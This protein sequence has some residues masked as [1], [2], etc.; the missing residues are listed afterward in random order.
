MTDRYKLVHFYSPTST[1]GSCST[2]EGP[3]GAQERLRRPGQCGGRGELE[4]GDGPPAQELKVPARPTQGGVRPARCSPSKASRRRE[5]RPLPA[6]RIDSVMERPKI[7]RESLEEAQMA[8]VLMPGSPPPAPVAARDRC[9]RSRRARRER[10]GRSEIAPTSSWSCRTTRATA[11][12]PATA[13]RSS[14]RR[15]STPSTGESVRFTDFHVSP[16]CAPTRMRADDRPARVQDRRHAHDPRARAAEPE[17]DDARPGAEVGR[18]HDGHLRQVAPRR[19]GRRISPTGA[20]STRC[21]S[22]AAAASARRTRAVAAMRRATPTSTRPSCT[23]ARSRRPKGYC[24]D[25]FFGQAMKWMDEQSQGRRTVLRL[26]HPQRRRTRRCNA[27]RS[28]PS[29]YAG[30]VPDE[31]REV[32]RHDREHR[33]QRR[34]AAGEAQASGASRTTR[35]SSS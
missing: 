22:T 16:T 33:R 8:R 19:R 13:I 29:G 5:R 11:I 34:P 21:S 23:T 2:S 10:R 20:A 24:T 4:A 14:R 1:T 25:V 18:L 31:R 32:L 7:A 12:S 26:H 3:P 17:G 28:T 30:K 35:W 6:P 27:R 15:T 9:D